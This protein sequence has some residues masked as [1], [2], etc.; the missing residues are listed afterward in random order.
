MLLGSFT[1]QPV[2]QLP[3]DIDFTPVIAGRTFTALSSVV[4]TP[5][6]MT[7]VS[8]STTGNVLQLYVAGGTDAQIYRWVVTTTITIGGRDTVVQDEFDVLVEEI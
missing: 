5:T 2:E 3:V 4:T 6:G 8:Q 1:K 7:L